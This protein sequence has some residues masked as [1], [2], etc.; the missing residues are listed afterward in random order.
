MIKEVGRP[1][2]G[3]MHSLEKVITEVNIRCLK[4]FK[5]KGLK[6]LRV[7]VIQQYGDYDMEKQP[8]I[9]F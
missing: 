1:R 8:Q 3:E 7:K 2:I 5:Q 4:G 9:T 6:D